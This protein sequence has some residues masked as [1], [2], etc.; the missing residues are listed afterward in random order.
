MQLLSVLQLPEV[1]RIDGD[2]P[3]IH[4]IITA[5]QVRELIK[6]S[7]A[8]HRSPVGSLQVQHSLQPYQ[9]SAF[10]SKSDIFSKSDMFILPSV[11][12]SIGRLD[13]KCSL[14]RQKHVLHIY[15][16]YVWALSYCNSWTGII[17]GILMD[18]LSQNSNFARNCSHYHAGLQKLF[19]TTQLIVWCQIWFI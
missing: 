19:P 16:Y 17:T 15:E 10:L 7:G 9:S 12:I 13:Q 5:Q 11:T 4:Y 3:R 2:P 6:E 18:H 8:A 14:H 1:A